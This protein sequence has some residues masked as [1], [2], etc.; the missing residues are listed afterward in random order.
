MASWLINQK[1]F[2]LLSRDGKDWIFAKTEVLE[3]IVKFAPFWLK[4]KCKF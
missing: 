2:P 4:V 3:E 1:S